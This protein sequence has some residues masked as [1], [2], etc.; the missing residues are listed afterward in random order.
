MRYTV[1]HRQH[2]RQVGTFARATGAL[3]TSGLTIM[4]AQIENVSTSAGDLAWDIFW[5]V[6]PEHPERQPESRRQEVRER[7][8]LLMDSLD[9]PL[10]PHRRKWTP[11]S[12]DEP[13]SVN[14]L[15]VK[16]VFDNETVDRYT[17]VSFF[18]YD[19]VGLLYRIASVLAAQRARVAFRQD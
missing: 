15:P 10:P 8:C 5:V 6:D 3:S 9:E 2:E 7:I 1:V 11:R 14:V 18:A 19:E 17:I 12:H 16:V 13:D 4:R